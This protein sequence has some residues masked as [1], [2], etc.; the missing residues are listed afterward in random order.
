MNN[1]DPMQKMKTSDV[2]FMPSFTT[3]LEKQSYK[4]QRLAGA[5][6]L[7]GQFGFDEGVTV[8]RQSRQRHSLRG[9]QGSR[10]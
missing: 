6:R 5:C 2:D 7:F 8:S 1:H 3:P 9:G 4:K 10:Y